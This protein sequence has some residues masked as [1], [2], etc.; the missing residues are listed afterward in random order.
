MADGGEL[1]SVTHL[2]RG[3]LMAS[4]RT[5][6]N[7]SAIPQV[8]TPLVPFELITKGGYKPESRSNYSLFWTNT[9]VG[10]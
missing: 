5:I 1:T 10:H 7:I 3:R 9:D 2:I 6:C 8:Y 4:D